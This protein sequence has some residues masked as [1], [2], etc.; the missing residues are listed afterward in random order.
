MAEDLR[1][2]FS[3]DGLITT[4]GLD[5]LADGS[6]IVSSSIDFGNPGD[7]AA[8]I[9][10]KLDG[11]SGGVGLVEIYAQWSNDDSDFSDALNDLPVCTV[12][13]DTTTAVIKV[14]E[15]P[16]I[17]QYVKLRILN[18]SGAALA[19]SGNVLRQ[20]GRTVDQA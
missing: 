7:F 14:W 1:Q 17:T 4:S 20:L 9:E 16:V 5:S 12:Q 15:L 6:E 3:A 18:N 2:N 11:L 8:T 13:M 19:A 10:T